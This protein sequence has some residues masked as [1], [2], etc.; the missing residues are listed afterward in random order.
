MGVNIF[1]FKLFLSLNFLNRY[2]YKVCEYNERIVEILNVL[3]VFLHDCQLLYL[4]SEGLGV[5]YKE[6]I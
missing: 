4:E 5:V 3:K 6:R 1:V 2:V